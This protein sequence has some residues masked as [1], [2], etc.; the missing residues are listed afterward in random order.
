[1]KKPTETL[2]IAILPAAEPPSNLREYHWTP[3]VESD[4]ANRDMTVN[5]AAHRAL[6]NRGGLAPDEK[7]WDIAV[8]AAPAD[9]PRNKDGNPANVTFHKL[10]F[11][12]R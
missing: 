1:M 5:L 10:S 12:R 8:Y 7:S 11:T 3:W 2:L 4:P 9:T 6:R